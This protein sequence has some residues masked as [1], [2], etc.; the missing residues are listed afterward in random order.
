MILPA[1]HI[2]KLLFTRGLVSGVLF[3]GTVSAQAPPQYAFT[4]YSAATGLAANTVNSLVQ[5]RT[6]YIWLATSNGLQRYDG[7][8]YITFR[9]RAADARSLPEN[10]LLQVAIDKAGRIWLLFN[11]GRTGIFH[12][13]DFSFTETAFS[14]P[15]INLSEWGDKELKVGT[16]GHI[17]YCLHGFGIFE[18]S[19]KAQRFVAVLPSYNLPSTWKVWDMAEDTLT[20]KCWFSGDFGL[21][22]FNRRSR[23]LSYQE[24]N[25]ER[26]PL[27]EQWGRLRHTSHLF[28]DQQH[29]LWLRSWPYGSAAGLV[30][31]F[32]LKNNQ[33]V[34]NAYNFIPI[35]ENY[36]EPRRF[37][38]Q[39]NGQIWLTGVRILARY[40]E[41]ENTFS[42]IRPVATGA[43]GID[44]EVINDLLEDREGNIWI[45]TNNNGLHRF[46]PARQSFSNIRPRDTLRHGPGDRSVL[47]FLQI[48]GKE[49][50]AGTWGNGIHRYDSN[51]N[52]IPLRIQGLNPSCLIWDMSYAKDSQTI[53]I[54]AQPGLY[55]YQETNGKAEYYNPFGQQYQTIRQVRE[56]NT[57]NLWIGTQSKGLFK[58]AKKEKQQRRLDRV[59]KI[60]GIPERQP[61]TSLLSDPQGHMWAATA[62]RG[63]FIIDTGSCKIIQHLDRQQ[64]QDEHIT[65]LLQYDDSTILVLS[66]YLD[67]YNIHTGR[68]TPVPLPETLI[69]DMAAIQRDKNGNL[70]ITA[71]NGLVR[72]DHNKK[73]SKFFDRSTG[74]YN[75]SFEPGA[76]AA[77]TDG[78]LLFGSSNQFIAFNPAGITCNKTFPDVVITGFSIMDHSLPVDSLL[79]RGSVDL[80]AHQNLITIDFSSFNYDNN[81]HIVYKL[82]GLDQ[83]WKTTAGNQAVYSYLPPGSYTLLLKSE[84][85]EGYANGRITRLPIRVHPPFWRTWWFNGLLAIIAGAVVY[86]L[87]TL[88]IKRLLA[89][90][91]VRTKLARDLHDDIGSSLSTINILSQ[92]AANKADESSV[93]RDYLQKITESSGRMME[94]MD[95][96]IW[97]INPVNDTLGK[98][99]VRLRE[100]MAEALEPKGI[101]YSF[102]IADRIRELKPDPESRRDLFLICKEAINNIVKY[103]GATHV[104]LEVSRT[105]NLLLITITDNG[106]GFQPSGT[107]AT[108]TGHGLNNMQAR[109]QLLRGT[110]AI[111]SAPGQ[112]TLIR[113]SVPIA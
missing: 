72:L 71:S 20:G 78:R 89:I 61:V 113:L 94:S 90:E 103:A 11:S 106:K 52:N 49:I 68:A 91:K 55:A 70:W 63:I 65:A 26:E 102:H 99:F 112:G 44:Y 56:D 2:W 12:T 32:D 66:R 16:D 21:A 58:L 76:S 1:K 110:F 50:L 59:C 47:S 67:S 87:H 98:M 41:K 37:T 29:R 48:K 39:K 22:V 84:N 86:G 82:E 92:V 81:F 31:A 30:Y 6:G 74:I 38:M 45:A 36:N 64:L 80:S 23:V 69:P 104:A 83:Q 111:S 9:H 17:Q 60:Q 5:D 42:L 100:F 3:W 95:D 62:G 10:N 34:L 54:G 93:S 96:I 13:A 28:I 25:T 109:A 101:D 108:G 43:P 97:S 8:R 77:L 79:Q 75:D 107:R 46:N 15:G 18:Y 57:G 27:I 51:F 24:H 4:H 7:T 53:W 14:V 105:G 85:P 88:R 19:D 35:V 73:T 40:Q 33:P